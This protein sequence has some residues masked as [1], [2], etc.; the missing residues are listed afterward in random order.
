MTQH[1]MTIVNASGGVFRADVNVALP[2]LDSGQSGTSAPP[3]LRALMYWN[4]TTDTVRRQRN[5]ANTV[6]II[7]D[8]LD[9]DR[10]FNTTGAYTALL[11]D[12][13]KL[14]EADATSA[15]LTITLPPAA[16]AGDG[17]PLSIKNTAGANNLVTLDGNASETIDGQATIVLAQGQAV[18]LRCDG[19][20]W[21]VETSNW[22]NAVFMFNGGPAAVAAGET[23]FFTVE[24]N[25]V[26]STTAIRVPFKCRLRNMYVRADGPPGGAE[27]FTFTLRRNLGAT[28]VTAVISA[29]ANLAEDTTNA[30]DYAAGDT[31]AVQI[32]ASGGASTRAAM[33]ASIEVEELF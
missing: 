21:F 24:L 3:V 12:Y 23:W 8:T 25:A 30:V 29:G 16:D 1:D 33:S 10:S 20:N 11:R 22:H 26:E 15:A 4:D 17:F 27:T 2:A 31:I 18:T 13:G 7:R 32:V 14:I 19:A 9:A 5:A 28:A 6:W